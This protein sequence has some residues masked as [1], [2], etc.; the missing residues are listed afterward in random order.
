MYQLL[1]A[2]FA[3][4]I[5]ATGI[6]LLAWLVSAGL[7]APIDPLGAGLFAGAAGT[8]W[9]LAATRL[10]GKA[11]ARA[12][13]LSAAALVMVV[14]VAEL[15]LILLTGTYTGVGLTLAILGTSGGLVFTV[16]WSMLAGSG[17]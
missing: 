16:V 17:R 10:L 1:A 6:A 12:H 8:F 5:I 14:T 9:L 2:G 13:Y 4:L 3:L 11:R 7:W 15:G